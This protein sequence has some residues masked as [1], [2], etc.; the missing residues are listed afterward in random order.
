[1]I[2]GAHFVITRLNYME[3]QSFAELAK[4]SGVDYIDFVFETYFNVKGLSVEQAGI[5]AELLRNVQG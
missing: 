3:I 1:M 2:I 4:R 5:A